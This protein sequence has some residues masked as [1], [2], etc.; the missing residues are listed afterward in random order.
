MDTRTQGEGGRWQ[1]SSWIRPE[2][3]LAIY[4]RD[5][6]ACVWCGAPVEDGTAFAL[7]HLRPRSQGGAN[8]AANLVTACRRCNS[9]RGARSVSEFA[10]AVAEY[11]DHGVEAETIIAHV[12]AC[13]RRAL[14]L[15][16]AKV[17]ISRR[18]VQP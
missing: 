18:E 10:R 11:L 1:G 17:I 6:L 15:A 9:S 7:D 4:L 8:E 13:R 12:R 2:K 5:G 14:P 3:R 16:E